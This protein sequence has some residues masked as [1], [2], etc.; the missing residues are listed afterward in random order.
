MSAWAS[1]RA[2]A[3]FVVLVVL[4]AVAFRWPAVH[5]G[6][7]SDDYAQDAMLRGVYPGG[8]YAPFDAYAFIRNDDSTREALLAHGVMPWWTGPGAHASV[9]RPLSS[10]TLAIDRALFPADEPGALVRWHVHSLLWL[11]VSLLAAAIALRRILSPALSSLALAFLACDIAFATP[12]I[13]I[14]NR[15][16]MVSA[17]FAWL[18][19]WAH[20]RWREGTPP[21]EPLAE[22]P[23]SLKGI[24]LEVALLA[25]AFGGGEYGIC[26]L[27]YLTAYELVGPGRSRFRNVGRRLG[28]LLP[29]LAV[30]AVY[31]VAHVSLGYGTRGI[32]GY[33]GIFQRPF[34]WL[35]ATVARI[36]YLATSGFWGAP[37]NPVTG[38]LRLVDLELDLLARML[39]EHH[40]AIALGMASL[41]LV[42]VLVASRSL[43]E[44]DRRGVW[45]LTLGGLLSIAPVAAAPPTTR[46]LIIPAMGLSVG[47]GAIVLAALRPCWQALRSGRATW[48]LLPAAL[49]GVSLVLG[50]TVFEVRWGLD[51]IEYW[52]VDHAKIARLV[53]GGDLLEQPL[54]GRDVVVLSLYEQT[55]AL[56]GGYILRARGHEPPRSWLTL[57]ML[58]QP[59]IVSR[60]DERTLV[61][62]S[63]NEHWL[64]TV[65][66]FY[67]QEGDP[68]PRGSVVQFEGL[69]AEVLA[70][71]GG[72][73]TKVR[74]VFPTSIDDPRYL[75]VVNRGSTLHRWEP[76]PVGA[77]AGI[78]RS[79]LPSSRAW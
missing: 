49:V 61:I 34:E 42:L 6:L 18:A 65:P 44:H 79:T 74:F 58:T 48:R 7:H 50:H 19:L 69:R 78:P 72:R 47:V 68:L 36:P 20:A 3:A 4:A 35:E 1:G 41:A 54:A 11:A 46:L 62:R 33:V 30:T 37:A 63:I 32:A 2:H 23:A 26:A 57:S 38:R 75:F 24:A 76:I 21:D 15:C 51:K 70:D 45:M 27:G 77:R 60:P 39:V 40:A 5:A 56:Y 10:A 25:L 12:V 53:E 67:R 59:A 8:D 29:A 71:A 28:A 55:V 16:S 73:P 52:D 9:W 64:G 17:T 13:W 22:A 43:S 14:A 31:L 66:R